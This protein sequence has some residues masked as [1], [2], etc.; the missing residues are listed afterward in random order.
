MG[1][2]ESKQTKVL[3]RLC[4]GAG[5][6]MPFLFAFNKLRFSCVKANMKIMMLPSLADADLIELS[7]KLFFLV[8]ALFFRAFVDQ[9]KATMHMPATIGKS[10]IWGNPNN[11]NN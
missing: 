7:L 5:W 11:I 4:L 9:N 2:K 1:C 10:T 6:S 3:I 8:K